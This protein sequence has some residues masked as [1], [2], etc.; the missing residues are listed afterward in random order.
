MDIYITQIGLGR[1]VH[2]PLMPEEITIGADGRL[3]SYDL[4]KTGE[5]KIPEGRMLKTVKWDGI[6]PGISRKKEPFVRDWVA[7]K[8]LDD[9][10]YKW[11]DDGAPLKLVVTR[12]NINIDCYIASYE[13]TISGGYGDIAYSIEFVEKVDVVVKPI[14]TATSS[15]SSSSNRTTPAKSKTYT[16]KS[17]DCLWNIAK[18]QYGKGSEWKKIYNANKTAIEAEAK[19]RGYKSSNN[20]NLIFPGQTLSIP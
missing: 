15:T 20:G 18:A 8:F 7:P 19:R 12:T 11:R 10:L 13:S 1:K 9:T 6:L 14:T 2:I 16:I 17:G 5:V 3:A 4:I